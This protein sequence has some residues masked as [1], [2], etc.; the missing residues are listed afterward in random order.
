MEVI[1]LVKL[2]CDGGYWHVGRIS[3]V[4]SYSSL[5]EALRNFK[6]NIRRTDQRIAQR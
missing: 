1:S 2:L 4:S 6:D 3:R 5:D